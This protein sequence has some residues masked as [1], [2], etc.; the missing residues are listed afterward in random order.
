MSKVLRKDIGPD[1]MTVTYELPF[2]V[3]PGQCVVIGGRYFAVAESNGSEATVL[4]RH[5]GPLDVDVG[6]EVDLSGPMGSGFPNID[7]ENAVIVCGGTGIGACVSVLNY[8]RRRG[9]QTWFVAYSRWKHPFQNQVNEAGGISW[10]TREQ[11][12]PKTPF[13]PFGVESFPQGTQVFFAGT[14][15]LLESIRQRVEQFGISSNNINL[16]Y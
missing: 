3:K 16:N 15:E 8:R 14:L 9:L 13:T 7:C 4:T 2:D 11:D 5:G 6:S 10:V 1:F 12:R